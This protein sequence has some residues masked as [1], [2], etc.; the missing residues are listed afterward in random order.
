MSQAL[1]MATFLGLVTSIV[2][3]PSAAALASRLGAVAMPRNDR[4]GRTSV[5]V[6]GGLALTAGVV[7]GSL[8]LP[9][10][11][12]DRAALLCGI[13]AMAMLGLADDLVAVPPSR[14]LA[15]EAM[16]AS[17][18]TAAV[19][20]GLEGPIRLVAVAG[21]AV[22][23]P[24][25]INATNLVDN[26]DGLASLLSAVSGLA[27][28]GIAAAAGISTPGG[29]LALVV[30]AAC[31]GFLLFNRPPARVFMGDSG[32]LML[33]FALAACS[34]LIIRD[35]VAVPGGAHLAVAMA[36]P[37][38]WAFQVGDLAMVF[39]TRLRRHDPPFQ[40]NVDH[41]SHRLMGAGLGPVAMLVVVSL[42]AAAVG[43]VA[44]AIAA[45]IGDYVLVALVAAAVAGLVGAFEAI[46]AWR[47]PFREGR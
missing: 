13:T 39:V 4:W 34:V 25:A 33:G 45:W 31:L 11:L 41:T 2:L 29:P 7:L 19:T 42:S 27:L 24:V 37:L 9:M 17:A 32:S 15:L 44:V 6:L 36:I 46:V 26:A 16:T 28:A 23:I 40:G 21:A 30:S 14:R 1:M 5:P 18:F 47:L 3:M 8:A 43:A 10:S 35:A 12:L 22:C 38:A 20:G